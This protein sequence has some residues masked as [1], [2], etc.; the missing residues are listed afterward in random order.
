EVEYTFVGELTR[1]A[2]VPLPVTDHLVTGW[3]E[4]V[5]AARRRHRTRRP[6]TEILRD[7]PH[8][9]V[10]APR[11]FEMPELPPQV[12]F[13]DAPDSQDHWPGALCALA[14]DGVL[15]RSYLVER[16]VARLMRGGRSVDQR[17]F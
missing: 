13:Y 2:R 8:T 7:D 12:D 4:L 3:T 9:A 16:C 5:G 6:L 17:F 15:D 14:G 11:L 1:I 10:L